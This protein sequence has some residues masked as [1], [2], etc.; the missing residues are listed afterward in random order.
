M[1]LEVISTGGRRKDFWDISG[2]LELYSLEQLLNFYTERYPYNNPKTVIEGLTNFSEADETE[3]P[4]CLKGKIWELIKLDI[5]EAVE[6]CRR[7]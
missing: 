2:L 5:E 4:V 7:F 1:K 3:D 6:N